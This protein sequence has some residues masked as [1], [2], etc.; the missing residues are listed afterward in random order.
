MDNKKADLVG[1]R[2]PPDDPP[3]KEISTGSLSSTVK[4]VAIP[5]PL[6]FINLD[7]ISC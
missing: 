1:S 3:G 2:E 4:K 6:F 7:H 5:A